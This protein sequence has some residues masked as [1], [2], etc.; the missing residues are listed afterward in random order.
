MPC[1]PHF[2]RRSFQIFEDPEEF[3]VAERWDPIFPG[4]IPKAK[5]GS[6]LVLDPLFFKGWVGYLRLAFLGAALAFGAA[7]LGAAFLAAAFL[8][9]AA[10]FLAALVTLAVAFFATVLAFLT[11]LFLADFLEEDFFGATPRRSS[12][13]PRMFPATPVTVE[14][15]SVEAD[16]AFL[17]RSEAFLVVFLAALFL[18]GVVFLTGMDEC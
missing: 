18:A 7:F 4:K 14:R 8:T 6:S 17:A 2:R 1:A 3:E 5:R 9:G 16:L 13:L 10:A 12:T 11:G 15:I